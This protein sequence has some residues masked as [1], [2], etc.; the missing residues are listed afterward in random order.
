MLAVFPPV[1]LKTYPVEREEIKQTI[2]F[3]EEEIRDGQEIYIYYRGYPAFL[4]YK[5]IGFIKL[6]NRVVIGTQQ[7]LDDKGFYSELARV[8]GPTW[9]LFTHA[10]PIKKWKTEETVIIRRLGEERKLLKKSTVKGSSV[11]LF[12]TPEP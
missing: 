11:Y 5:D 8:A 1:L 3:L 10:K 6:Q 4:Y 2:E 9:F 12:D 7:I